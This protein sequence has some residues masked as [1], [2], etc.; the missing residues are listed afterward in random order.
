M[1]QIKSPC[2]RSAELTAEALSIKGELYIQES[3]RLSK[4]AIIILLGEN[5]FPPLKKEI[6]DFQWVD[7]GKYCSFV[8]PDLIRHP[9]AQRE[10]T[11]LDSGS[12]P[13]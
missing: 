2:P 6:R 4:Y 11:A 12:S 5:A 13:E 3:S 7:M 8:M 10:Q 9:G 1:R